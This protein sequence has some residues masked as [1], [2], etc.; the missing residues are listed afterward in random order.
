M[1]SMPASHFGLRG[2]GLIQPGFTADVV[3]LD[4]ARLKAVGTLAA[5]VAYAEGIEHV[6]VNGAFVLDG[7]THTGSRPG[8]NLLRT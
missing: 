1:T 7:G 2:R 6:I 4:V 3:V 5:P 8:R